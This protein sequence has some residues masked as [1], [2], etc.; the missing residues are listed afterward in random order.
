MLAERLYLL[1]IRLVSVDLNP[2]ARSIIV[3]VLSR[4]EEEA[5]ARPALQSAVQCSAVQCRLCRLLPPDSLQSAQQV[6]P[7]T[8]Q[9]LQL[10]SC[11]IVWPGRL[12]AGQILVGE[13]RVFQETASLIQR[14][15]GAANQ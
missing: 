8:A 5:Q 6:P 3:N 1:L 11:C 2:A 7:T 12:Q 10:Q 15:G 4:A 14:G 13:G 9:H